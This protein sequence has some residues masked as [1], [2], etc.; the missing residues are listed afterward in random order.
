MEQKEA[1][2]KETKKKEAPKKE[3]SKELLEKY[4]LHLCKKVQLS[5]GANGLIKQGFGKVLKDNLKLSDLDIETFN[6]QQ[7]NHHSIIIKEGDKESDYELVDISFGDFDRKTGKA[8]VVE[9]RL[10][11]K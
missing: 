10:V 5:T 8:E 2:K 4:G 11:K 6:E 9:N 7:F 1:P 3:T